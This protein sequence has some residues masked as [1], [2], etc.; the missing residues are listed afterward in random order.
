M[1][2]IRYVIKFVSYLIRK[3]VLLKFQVWCETTPGNIKAV[4]FSPGLFFSAGTTK[5]GGF[6]IRD[7]QNGVIGY[8]T[9]KSNYTTTTQEKKSYDSLKSIREAHN[10]I[11]RISKDTTALPLV[12]YDGRTESV[13]LTVNFVYL[14]WIYFDL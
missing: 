1:W 7:V 12:T 6:R 3:N 4:N 8:Y 13:Q 14:N 10:G 11:R 9:A 2:K 5:L